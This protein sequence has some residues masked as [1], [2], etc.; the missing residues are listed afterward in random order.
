MGSMYTRVRILLYVVTALIILAGCS[1]TTSTPAPT[2]TILT[3]DDRLAIYS[4]VAHYA[5]D[6]GNRM[7]TGAR[8]YPVLFVSP[9]L[10]TSLDPRAERW[11]GDPTPQELLPLLQD[12]VPRREFAPLDT[13]V[14]RDKMNA[15]REDGIWLGFGAIQVAGN[16]VRVG[17]K[18][19]LNGVNAVVYEY[20]LARQ[21]DRWIV[22]KATQL[23]IS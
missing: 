22:L 10:A 11:D 6:P 7:G 12:L 3:A 16:E 9:N 17:A 13:V 23:W 21:G 14:Q 15:V 5:F 18:T 8:H 1:A 20:Q 19:F 4:A 2:T